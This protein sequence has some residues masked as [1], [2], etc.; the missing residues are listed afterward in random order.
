[1]SKSTK[2]IFI[3]VLIAVLSVAYVATVYNRYIALE[4]DVINK[5]AQVDNQLQ[6]RFDLIPNLVSTVKGTAQQE[7]TVFS[8]LAEARTRYAGAN[9]LEQQVANANQV[10]S[11]LARLLV[12]TENYPNLKSSEAFTGLMTQL[13]GSENRLSVARKDYN[14][15]VQTLNTTIK[16]FPGRLVASLFGVKERPYFQVKDEAKQNPEVKF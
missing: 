13:E 14:D 7:Q 10:E 8:Q 6:R 3:V 15:S 4:E 2:I 16:R 1:M 5:W 11:A 12:I 9:N